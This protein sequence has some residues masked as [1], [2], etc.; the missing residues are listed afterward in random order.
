[1][2]DVGRRFAS[3]TMISEIDVYAMRYER[4]L[5]KTFVIFIQIQS[6]SGDL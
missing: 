3:P 2:K 5:L 1:M 6:C 4:P